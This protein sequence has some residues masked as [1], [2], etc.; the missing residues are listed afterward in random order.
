MPRPPSPNATPSILGRLSRE[1]ALR[2]AAWV[3]AFLK[4]AEAWVHDAAKAGTLPCIHV[5]DVVR[6]D[7]DA[8]RAW[9]RTGPRAPRQPATDA[10]AAAPVLSVLE[11]IREALVERE[12]LGA[13]TLPAVT[14]KEAMRRLGCGRVQVFKLLKSGV[15]VRAQ[16]VGRKTLITAES[17]DQLL[18]T[19]AAATG[20]ARKRRSPA[21]SAGR[22][23]SWAPM[24]LRRLRT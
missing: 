9:G 1:Q 6:F 15:L 21:S 4:V 10:D 5:G 2:D 16:K 20:P 22:S 7:P 18:R 11:E 13:R 24:D 14:L 8:I 17:I 23:R 3:A 19:P 12:P